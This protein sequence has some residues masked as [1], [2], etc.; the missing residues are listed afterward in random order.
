MHRNNINGAAAF[1]SCGSPPFYMTGRE[2]ICMRKGTFSL[3]LSLIAGA[4]Y[5]IYYF[6]HHPFV[7][8]TKEYY[9]QGNAIPLPQLLLP[10]NVILMILALAANLLALI[11][12]RSSLAMGA[13]VLYGVS[14]AFS[15]EFYPYAVLECVLC[16]IAAARIEERGKR[17]IP[18]DHAP[19]KRKFFNSFYM[20][21]DNDD[22]EMARGSSGA[23]VRTADT[24]YSG[25]TKTG[26][27]R[28]L[29]G[30]PMKADGSQKRSSVAATVIVVSVLTAFI[31]IG[32]PILAVRSPWRSKA[33][34]SRETAKTVSLSLA[35]PDLSGHW[36]SQQTT[37]SGGVEAVIEGASITV[38]YVNR[39]GT[40]NLFWAGSYER[41]ASFDEPYTWMSLKDTAK[42][43]DEPFASQN[44]T[45]VFIYQNGTILFHAAILGKLEMTFRMSRTDSP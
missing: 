15:P 33:G 12:Y 6:D 8:V 18:D 7:F 44:S 3:L 22:L 2:N 1:T 19:K 34:T 41:P 10:P 43:K 28:T 29:N 20:L 5:I 35:G 26:E 32:I 14:I 38:Y 4:G 11:C 39:D 9:F 16:L 37:Y 24:A 25:N 30:K 42:T 21:S 17:S 45:Q 27:V 36:A 13:S 23:S 40:K 31:G